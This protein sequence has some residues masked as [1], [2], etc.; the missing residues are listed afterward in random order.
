MKTLLSVIRWKFVIPVTLFVAAIVLFLVVFMDPLLARGISAVAS[1][2]NGAKVDVSGLKTKIFQGRLSIA[3]VQVTN[4]KEPMKNIV[5]AGPMAFE[6]SLGDIF[7]KR[8]VIPEAT[9][10]GL[11]FE[12]DR[13]TSGAL[14]KIEKEQKK[15]GKPSAASRLAEKYKNQFKLNL[16]GLKS[17]AKAKIEFDPK[18]LKLVKQSEALK[19]KSETLP[20]QWEAKVK[21]LNAEGR[22]KQIEADLESIKNT[23]TKGPEAITGIPASLNKLK[24]AKEDLSTLKRDVTNLKTEALGEVQTLKSEIKSLP[25]AKKADIDNL[26]SRLNWDFADPDRLVESLIGNIFLTRLQTALGYIQTIRAHMPSQKEKE[27]MPPKPR[28][29]GIEIKFPTPAAPP[30]FWLQKAGLDGTYQDISVA[31]TLTHLTSDP[32]RVGKPFVLKLNGRKETQDFLLQVIADHTGD[33]KKDGFE[34]LAEGIDLKKMASGEGLERALA[35]GRAQARLALNVI[36]E[37]LGGE[38]SAKIANLKIDDNVFLEQAGIPLSGNL[39]REDSLKA[40]FMRNVA[41]AMETMPQVSLQAQVFGTWEDPSLKF[42]SNLGGALTNVIKDS[43]GSAIQEQKKQLEAELDK[44]LKEKTKELEAKLA[45]LQNQV[46]QK[47]GGLD[48]RV[49]KAINDA[50]GIKLMSSEG[51]GSS[52]IPGLKVPSLDKFF[53]K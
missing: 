20:D 51:E 38:L 19:E 13:K 22:L 1:K 26:L 30:R 43:V 52:P 31:G 37:K 2:L 40:S 11:K 3:N 7:S 39:S 29:K 49:Q 21:N 12:T 41:R 9:L 23:P 42:S 25:A 36:G 28:M 27:S 45:G 32:P 48:A 5:E 14:P 46:T 44:V 24:K 50:T 33:I 10:G 47:V 18:E 16:E 53:K 35:G 6:L 15:E 8:V 34:V 17:Q 4:P